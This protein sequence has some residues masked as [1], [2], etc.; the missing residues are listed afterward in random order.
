MGMTHAE[1]YKLD[2]NV[3]DSFDF[4]MDGFIYAM[5]YPTLQEL[6]KVI[7]VIDD[8]KADSFAVIDAVTDF[9]TPSD[10]KA[11]NIKEVLRNKNIK[12]LQNFNTMIRVKFIGVEEE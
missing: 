12:V 6:D 3:E 2:D 5:K 9:I 1:P 10:P 11:P 8:D 7:K 4:Q